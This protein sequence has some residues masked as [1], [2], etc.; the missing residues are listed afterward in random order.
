MARKSVSSQTIEVYTD[1]SFRPPNHGAYAFVVVDNGTIT[2]EHVER[3]YNTTINK[4]ELAAVA[5]VLKHF[6]KPSHLTIYSDSQ[7]AVFSIT[8]WSK[9]WKKNNWMTSLGQP[10]KNKEILEEILELC[11]PHKVEVKW[12]RGHAGN[13][14]N[15][16]CD[17]LAHT[18]TKEMQL[19]PV[20]LLPQNKTTSIS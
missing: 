5:A 15:V 8:K 1:G 3:V 9:A 19:Y 10:V 12:V 16:A 11:K 6:T 13:V 2:Y 20:C 17:K 18:A 14:F 7:Y 4:M